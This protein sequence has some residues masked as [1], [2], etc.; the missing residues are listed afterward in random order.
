M[1]IID[2]MIDFLEKSPTKYHFISQVRKLLLKS[3]LKDLDSEDL[4]FGMPKKG[5]VSLNRDSLIAYKSGSFESSLILFSSTD[6]ISSL[7]LTIN[8]D[9]MGLNLNETCEEKATQWISR[10]LKMAG[11]VELKN[12]KILLFDSMSQIAL[13]QPNFEPFLFIDEKNIKNYLAD[14]LKVEKEELDLEKSEIYL[15]DFQK[16]EFLNDSKS[17]LNYHNLS[18]HAT[19]YLALKSFLQAEPSNSNIFLILSSKESN[20]F[21]FE[22]LNDLH[23]RIFPEKYLEILKNSYIISVNGIPANSLK[24]EVHENVSLT[25]GL[26]FQTNNEKVFCELKKSA[27]KFGIPYQNLNKEFKVNLNGFESIPSVR[28]SL[29]LFE[30]ESCRETASISELFNLHNLLHEVFQNILFK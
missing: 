17:T 26:V 18:T 12:N 5:F 8:D 28:I 14:L 30:C 24:N 7:K 23:Q 10:D 1:E 15:S 11:K 3:K 4:D 2:G 29:P 21:L 6:S 20:N 9:K 27:E 22:K 16:A 13:I 25:K 19:S